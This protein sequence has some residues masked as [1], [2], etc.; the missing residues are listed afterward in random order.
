MKDL[1][2]GKIRGNEMNKKIP[3]SLELIN[4]NAVF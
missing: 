4:E 2:P 3:V 1:F